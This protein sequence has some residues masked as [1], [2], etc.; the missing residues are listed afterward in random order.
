[1]FSWRAPDGSEVRAF[2]LLPDYS[3]F[4]HVD[5][6]PAAIARVVALTERFA[7]DLARV[8]VDDFLLCNGTDHVAVQPELPL[9]CAG[10]ERTFPG[11]RFVVSSYGDYVR[12][13]RPREVQSWSGE[14]VGGRLQNVLRG[15]NSARLYIKQANERAERRLLEAETLWAL[16]CLRGGGDFP[17]ADFTLAWR[18][19]LRCQSH[20]AICGCS[21]DEVHRDML[22][23]YASLERTLGVLEQEALGEASTEGSLSVGVVNPLPYRRS[24]LVERVG[25]E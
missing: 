1:M 19:L 7:A 18:E 5:D 12:A 11:I 4:A 20:D 23:R 2:Q 15:V 22:L 25:A 6:L 21:C 10:L 14:L 9:L 3:N 8:G 17:V 16:R 13:V 24:I